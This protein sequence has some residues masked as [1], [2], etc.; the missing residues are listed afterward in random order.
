MKNAKY[1]IIIFVIASLAAC[2]L[3]NDKNFKETESGLKYLFHISG[4]DEKPQTGDILSMQMIYTVEDTVLFDSRLS[5]M[6]VYIPLLES[7]YPGDIYEAMGMMAVGD[8]A[9]FIMNAAD[10]FMYTAGMME[11]P[12]F[13]TQDSELIFDI[14]LLQAMDEEG[15]AIEEQR[16]MEEQM[17]RD[18][19][20]AEQEEEL[21]LEYIAEEG[22]TVLPTESGL[23]YVEIETGDGPR[24]QPGNMVSV[25][26]EGR[27]LDGSVFDSSHERGE[28]IEFIL[29]QGWVIPGWDEGIGMMR[30]GGKARLVIPSHLGYGD[31]GAGPMIPAYSTLVFDVELVDAGEAQ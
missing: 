19:V 28:P 25:H 10:F 21:R 4:G 29:G 9:T 2:G 24:A 14:K 8:S 7:Q 20:R 1:L 27:L 17:A 3:G 15:F 11:L 18:L 23:Y 26:Y 30:V 5:D 31:R 16:M 6:P 12:P 22:I 13:I